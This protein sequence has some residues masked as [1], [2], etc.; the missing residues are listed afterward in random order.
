MRI[1]S[2]IVAVVLPLVIGAL[3]ISGS[4][5]FF[6]ASNAVSQVTSEFLD[7]KTDQLEQYIEGQ[8][9]ILVENDVA[10][11][12][13]MVQA[14]QSAV[15]VF[16]RSI[17]RSD[18]ELIFA[19]DRDG[20][21][22]MSTAPVELAEVERVALIELPPVTQRELGELRVAAEDRVAA[23]FE[24]APFGWRVF[25]TENRDVFYSDLDRITRR[26]ALFTLGAG[27]ITAIVLFYVVSRLTNP[28]T[29]VV[30]AM[31]SI[32]SSNDLSSQ[33]QVFYQDEIG[34]MSQT[35]NV[36]IAELE[37]AY[38]RI[39]R[40]AYEAV[41]SQKKEYKIRNIFQKYVPQQ[42]IDRFFENPESM[43]VGDNRELAVLFSDI[44]S[45]T[46][47]SEKMEP[48]VLVASLNRYFSVM[49]ELIMERGGVI[50]KYIGDAIMAFFGAPVSTENDALASVEAGIAMVEG[51]EGFN[52]QQRSAGLPEFK[53]G[54]GINFGLVTVGNIGTDRKMD[55]TVIGDM[56]NVASRL[57]GLTKRYKQAL[58]ISEYLRERIGDAIPT[59]IVDSVAVKGR[60]EGLR[61][62][63]ARRNLS[64]VERAAW[65]RHN[66]AMEDYYQ[67]QFDKAITGFSEVLTSLPEDYLA[68]TMIERCR[69]YQAEPPAADWDG[70]EVMTEK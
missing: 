69:L 67:R 62:H 37:K 45:F 58:I 66:V 35:F 44:R 33:V 34:E 22:A 30:G 47:I 10:G 21:V 28:V 64:D 46:S 20:A 12:T 18:T 5:A 19:V 70:V 32:I 56:V 2:K 55:Y 53:I 17:L 41:L 61:I 29:Q 54:V 27:L 24:F 3:A 59:R 49:V 57:E 25:V 60:K 1:R 26:T 36:M 51:L 50:D 52:E 8:W 31:R 14:A 63:T 16:A 40:H 4:S 65:E 43:L 38:G 42:L 23:R 7:F 11:R 6:I 39:K 13:D 48:D 15:E 9:R 68:T